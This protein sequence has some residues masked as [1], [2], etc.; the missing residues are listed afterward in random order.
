MTVLTS[1]IFVTSK[2]VSSAMGS[3]SAWPIVSSW[4]MV[5]VNSLLW[6]NMDTV[7]RSSGTVAK[8]EGSVGRSAV[9][10]FLVKL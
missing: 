8:A 7:P 9:T 2:R 10:M 3:S 5:A 1:K 6:L 4:E